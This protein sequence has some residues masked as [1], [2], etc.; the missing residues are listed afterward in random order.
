[1]LKF[2]LFLYINFD[3]D[4]VELLLYPLLTAVLSSIFA[5]LFQHYFTEKKSAEAT[6]ASFSTTKYIFT[7]AAGVIA[8]LR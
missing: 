8:I 4:M 7:V 5:T 6:K 2:I 1:M 3:Y